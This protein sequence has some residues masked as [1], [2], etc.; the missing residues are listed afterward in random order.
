MI[1]YEIQLR[2]VVRDKIQSEKNF[3][4][5]KIYQKKILSEKNSRIFSWT[6]FC[7]GL[8]LSRIS[9]ALF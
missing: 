2:Y 5:K 9:S 1:A 4:G 7:L 8:N 3:V 6:E